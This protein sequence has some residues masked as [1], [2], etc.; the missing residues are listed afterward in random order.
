MNNHA[1]LA[2]IL[3]AI[4][5]PT[6][7][8]AYDLAPIKAKTWYLVRMLLTLSFL[9]AVP[10][11]MSRASDA[12][13]LDELLSKLAPPPSNEAL[14]QIPDLGRRL[15]ALRSYVRAGSKI[16]ER[17]SWTDDEIKAFQ[18]SAEQQ[19]LLAEIEAVNSHFRQAN[20]GYEIYVHGT[21]RS[22]DHQ[23]EKWNI[24]ESV[25]VAAGEILAAWLEKF[26]DERQAV[27]SVNPREVRNW[28][29]GFRPSKRANLAAPGLTRHGRAHAI[30]FQV[31]RDG[32][33]LAAA[34]SKEI[35]PVWRA[36]GWDVKLKESMEA[37]G[38]SF[39]GPLTAPVEPWHYDYNPQTQT[40]STENDTN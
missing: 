39:S 1:K 8:D 40:A 7:T 38:P 12:A 15:L 2:T 25:G 21:V 19:A 24:N 3:V 23:I 30:D 20:P 31:M 4:T 27:G 37:A 17:W 16:A 18:G 14:F 32:Q 10:L 34:N 6:R 28:L 5:W 29:S 22:L 33:I 13:M 36:E 9:V 26:G 11:N 35:E